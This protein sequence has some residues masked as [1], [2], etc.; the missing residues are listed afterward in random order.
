MAEPAGSL[1]RHPD[2]LRLWGGQ[3]LAVFGAQV[4]RTVL[5]LVAVILLDASATQ[6]GVLSALSQLPF[7]LFLL[8]GAWVDRV[9]RR[10]AMVWTD[11]G[12]FALLASVPVLHLAGWLRIEVLWVVVLGL[13]VL[14]VLFETAYHAYLPS[15]AGRS[16]LAEGNQKLELSRSAAQFAG[17]GAAGL[18]VTAVTSA[19]VLVASAVTYLASALLLALIRKPDPAPP[20]A[21]Q[22][23]NV[24][25]AVG[26]GLRW[27]LRHPVLRAITVATAV[28]WLFYSALQTLYVLYLVRELDVPAGWVAAIF[29]AAGPG[30]VVG[31]WLSIRAVKRFG[32]GRTVMWSVGSAVTALLLVPA[33]SWARA[34]WLVI[35]LLAVSQFGYGLFSQI[36]T[37]VQ[38]TLRQV[39]TPDGLQGRVVATLRALS[40]A[41]VPVG[42]LVAGVAAD[43]VGVRAVVWV[44]SIGV[45]TPVVVYATSVIPGMRD[46][47]S[48]EEAAAMAPDRGDHAG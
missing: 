22:R 44:A 3:T 45:L 28:F 9:R 47:P 4:A 41:M 19:L 29:A 32:V 17:P 25:K 26:E 2:F 43:A 27:V 20:P 14:G 15:L 46:L 38:T 12:R 1:R 33:A 13:G 34:P 5:P 6:M 18:A 16:L 21:H 42:A 48:E 35:G 40:L 24:L 11:L 39:V 10:R 30:A 37:V 7:L 31:S 8:A 36:G 23:P